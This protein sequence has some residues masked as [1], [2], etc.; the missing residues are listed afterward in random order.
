M[1]DIQISKRFKTKCPLIALGA[2]EFTATVTPQ[3][4]KLWAVFSEYCKML[5]ST[6]EDKNIK[7]LPEIRAGRA[8]YKVLGRDPDRYNLSAE[9]LLKRI[10]NKKD[11]Y[12]INNLVDTNNFLSVK[13][14]YSIGLYDLDKTEG[15]ISFDYGNEKEV[16]E[17]LAKGSFD[18][19]TLP[20]FRDAIS[21]FGSP[22]SDSRRTAIQPETSHVLMVFISFSGDT[23]LNGWLQSG[24]ALL[25]E[26]AH[27]TNLKT[28]II[29]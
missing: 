17:S 9:A 23:N 3:N 19:T 21:G 1:T 13:S 6:L 11:I 14:H 4:E 2:V 10:K 15:S 7:E 28:A 5:A 26:Y 18:V 12:Q 20:V 25:A 24:T 29:K 27:A 16:Y 8:A 22:T